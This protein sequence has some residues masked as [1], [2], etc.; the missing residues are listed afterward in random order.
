MD[1]VPEART[2]PNAVLATMLRAVEPDW[3]LREATPAER[4]FCSVY[5][6]V[7]SD[8]NRRELYAKASPD[9]RS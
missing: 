2:I 1:D 3:E 6:V 9:G 4:G 8:G 7:A 5:R